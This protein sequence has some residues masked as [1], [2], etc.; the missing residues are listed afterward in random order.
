MEGEREGGREK[1]GR[2]EGKK[3]KEKRLD[4]LCYLFFHVVYLSKLCYN[5]Q[6]EKTTQ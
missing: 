1:K 5:L 2:N 6:R 3:R 4:H